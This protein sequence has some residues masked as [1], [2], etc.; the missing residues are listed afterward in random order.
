MT[1]L[2]RDSAERNAVN[3]ALTGFQE[4]RTVGQSGNCTP[5]YEEGEGPTARV[6]G[7]SLVE[8]L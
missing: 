2:H 6:L 1:S 7:R 5:N 4:V 8:V 3:F